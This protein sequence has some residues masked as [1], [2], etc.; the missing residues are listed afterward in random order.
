MLYTVSET[1]EADDRHRL[2]VRRL[3]VSA[4]NVRYIVMVGNSLDATDD[5]LGGLREIL[6]S[7]VPLGLLIAGLGGWFL[8]RQEPGAGG[9]HG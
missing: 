2:A 4:A 5:E 9:G 6:A 7:V 3:T 1:D 8:A